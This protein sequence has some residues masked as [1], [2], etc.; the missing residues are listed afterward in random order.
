MRRATV[1]ALL[2]VTGSVCLGKG[3]ESKPNSPDKKVPAEPREASPDLDAIRAGS[4]AFVAAFNKR[5][6]KAIAELWTEDGQH[7]DD[8]GHVF[9]GRDAIGKVYAQFF[10]K[11][12]TAQ[13]RI[14]IDS[15]R[16]LS[17]DAAVEDGRAF[18][19]MAS[20]GTPSNCVY[21][22]VHVKKDGKWLMATVRDAQG[23]ASSARQN[24][25]D[26]QWLIGT[27]VAEEHGAKTESI[28]RWVA[29]GSFLERKHTT[30]RVDGT[31]ASGVQLIGWNPQGGYVQSWNF[32]SDGGHSIGVWTPIDGGWQAKVHGT[33]GDGIS[34]AAM[35]LLRRLD[36]NAYVWQSVQRCLGESTLPD[37]DEIVIKRQPEAK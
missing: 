10:S 36:D 18:V 14:D 3:Q 37:T 23:S 30:T 27:W 19:A 34:T 24:A 33:T 4:Q 12:L 32:T 1:L 7:I 26:L 21:T 5:D 29:D 2:M 28:C 22:A 9:N 11:N 20:A 25:A 35:N 6:A 13:I 31:T 8:T 15:L 16:L 17:P